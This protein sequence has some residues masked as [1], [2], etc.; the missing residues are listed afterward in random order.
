M[1]EKNYRNS[2]LVEVSEGAICYLRDGQGKPLILLHG[3]PLSLLTWRHNFGELALH[4]QVIAPDLPGYGMSHK[5]TTILTPESQARRMLEF[6]DAL[7]IQRATFIANSFGCAVALSLAFIQP[8]RVE[9]LVLINSVCYPAGPHSI[10][11][12]LRLQFS[13]L[14]LKACLSRSK[15]GIAFLKFGLR[16]SY[17]KTPSDFQDLVE[18]YYSLLVRNHGEQTFVSTLRQF[19]EEELEKIIPSVP[20]ETL[21][22][23]G[24]RDN[25]LPVCNAYRLHQDLPNSSLVVLSEFGHLVHEEAP[26]TV[27]NLILRF[28]TN[29]LSAQTKEFSERELLRC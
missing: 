29:S 25:V 28:M 22:I 1:L 9:K 7:N 10:E 24:C 14:L 16:R 12:F 6:M 8:D 17:G 19:K 20:H 13:S 23:W 5:E 21:I 2:Q 26:T 11:R 15:I 27:D 3:I 18:A 4:N